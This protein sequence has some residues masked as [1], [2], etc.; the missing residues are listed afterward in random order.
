M[1]P[2]GA[3]R[4]IAAKWDGNMKAPGWGFGITG[5]QSRRK[6]QTLVL[7]LVG[8][9]RDGSFG[10]EAIF[11][12]QQ[13]QLNKP[14]YVAA[15]VQL[16]AGEPGTVTFYVKDLSNDD[17][18][19]L[20]APVRHQIKGSFGNKLP[21]TLGARSGPKEGFF[22]GLLDDVRLSRTALGVQQLL[23]TAEG[24]NRHTVG[25]WQFEARPDVFRDSSG[26][27]L[28][29]KPAAHAGVRVDARRAALADFCHVLLNSSEF[30]YVD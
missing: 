4:T 13:I 8:D 26:N 18:P 10:E 25:Y 16:A 30:L 1:Y 5:K 24:I 2:S 12:D 3:V 9:K 28:D 20:I 19:L 14:Y 6:P 27:G 29:I 23:Y 22:E 17:E 21:L 15:A 11:S 7:Q